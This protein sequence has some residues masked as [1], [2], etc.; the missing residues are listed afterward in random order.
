MLL[1]LAGRQLHFDRVG[2]TYVLEAHL[3]ADAHAIGQG[4]NG[5][6]GLFVEPL[7]R[8]AVTVGQSG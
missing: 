4:N 5:L 3:R 2:P 1:L 6:A 7:T 8:N